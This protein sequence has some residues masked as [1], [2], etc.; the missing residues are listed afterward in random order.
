MVAVRTETPND[1]ALAPM[2][3]WA[4]ITPGIARSRAN[5]ANWIFIVGS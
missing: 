2:R 5:P 4:A 3:I 1:V